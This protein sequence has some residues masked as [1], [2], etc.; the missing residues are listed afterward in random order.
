[1]TNEQRTVVI[2]GAGSRRG[3]GRATAMRFARDGWAVVAADIDQEAAQETASIAASTH[4][5]P[6]LGLGCDVTSEQAIEGL[7]RAINKAELPPVGSVV[8]I[9]GIPAPQDFVSSSLADWDRVMSVNATGTY[10][11]IR[12]FV[13]EMISQRFGRIVTM[14]SVTAQHGGGV[15]SK[16]LYAAAKAA[17]IG[18]T[19]GLSR[20]LAQFGITANCIAP[21]A[22]ETDI[23]AGATDPAT[24]AALHKS[25]PLGRQATVE[26][27]A[28]AIAFFASSDGSYLTGVTLNINGGSYIA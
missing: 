6:T 22:V 14:S 21:G 8:P 24:E 11:L 9:A 2:S 26:D 19:R 13:Q 15:F 3:I 25:V 10:L 23:R 16:S 1:M 28:A 12:A 4:G 7:A 18:L 5:V 20:E 17:V 27:C